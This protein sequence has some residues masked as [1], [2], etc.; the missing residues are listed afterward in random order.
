MELFQILTRCNN[1]RAK[2]D[3]AY[4]YAIEYDEFSARIMVCGLHP[5]DPPHYHSP[6]PLCNMFTAFFL[7]SNMVVNS[8]NSLAQLN[9]F[10]GVLT[11]RPADTSAETPLPTDKGKG[12]RK[13]TTDAPA[14]KETNRKKSKGAKPTLPNGEGPSRSRQATADPSRRT[15][16]Q[17]VH[18]ARVHGCITPLQSQFL[19]GTYLIYQHPV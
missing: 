6:P 8:D 10:L 15:A 16:L 13:R 9:W 11:P 4:P 1:L 18:P 17:P 2:V 3:D 12:K 14:T 7:Q 19:G 5:H